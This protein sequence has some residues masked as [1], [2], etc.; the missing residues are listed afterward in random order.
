[1]CCEL[2]INTIIKLHYY[3]ITSVFGTRPGTWDKPCTGGWSM[4]QCW[5]WWL[6]GTNIRKRSSRRKLSGR[7]HRGGNCQPTDWTIFLTHLKK[8]LSGSLVTVGDP[9]T[10]TYH[11]LTG[12][13]TCSVRRLW[14]LSCVPGPFL[15]IIPK[16]CLRNCLLSSIKSCKPGKAIIIFFHWIQSSDI[17]GTRDHTDC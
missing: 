9:K 2:N 17:Q 12:E 6:T 14:L 1:M 11:T 3:N 15:L 8:H 16:Y 13:I 10:N 4:A 7:D 5:R